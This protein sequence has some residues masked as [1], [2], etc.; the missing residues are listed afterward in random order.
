MGLIK[1]H[2]IDEFS[3]IKSIPDSSIHT[4]IL[5]YVRGLDE[6]LEIEQFIREILYDPN[7]T[8]HGP[9]EIADILT[10]LHVKGNKKLAAFVIKGKS[11][12]KAT[13]KDITHQFAKL[14]QIPDIGLM[15]FGAVGNMQDDAQRDFIQTAVDANCDYLMIDVHD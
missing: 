6:K 15:V 10:D 12:K 8:P 2:D 9:T 11:F 4:S 13:S 3:E 7:K 5:D 14:R 1:I